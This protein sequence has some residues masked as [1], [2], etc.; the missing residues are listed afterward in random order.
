MQKKTFEK[1]QHPFILKVLKRSGLQGSYLNMI[2]AIYCKPTNNIKLDG[3]GA[4]PEHLGEP[5]WFPDP[6]ETSLCR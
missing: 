1:I 6:S 4:L 3:E 2:N 5:S